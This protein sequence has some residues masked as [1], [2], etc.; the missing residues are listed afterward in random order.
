[1]AAERL[2]R[3]KPAAAATAAAKESALE[4]DS[5]WKMVLSLGGAPSPALV[6]LEINPAQLTS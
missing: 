4:L 2:V 5:S 3:A 1:M 6:H